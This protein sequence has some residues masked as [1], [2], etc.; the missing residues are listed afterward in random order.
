MDPIVARNFLIALLIGALIGIEREKKKADE[1]GQSFGG[2]RTYTLLSLLGAA[3][4]WL[5]RELGTPWL[6]AAVLL[7]VGA[8]VVASF[9]L[10]ARSSPDMPGLTS[11][12]AAVVVCVL[13]ALVVVGNAMLAVA[14]AVVTSALLA[15]KQPLHSMVKRIGTDDLFAG[16][17]LLIASCI[18]LPLLPDHALDRWGALNPYALWLLVILISA[19][20]LLGYVAVRLLGPSRGAA[21]TGLA[22]GLVSSTATT[23]SFARTSAAQPDADGHALAA[24]VLLA[25]LVMAARLLVVVTLLNAPLAG[26]LAAPLGV[27]ATMTAVFAARHYLA[28]RSSVGPAGALPAGVADLAVRNPF[29]L[30]AAAQFGALF[31]LVMLATRLAQLHAPEVGVYLVSVLAGLVDVDAIALS[32]ARAPVVPG[33]TVGAVAI[34]L[35]VVSNTIVKTAMVALLGRGALRRHIGRAA[36]AIVP[37]AAAMAW[38]LA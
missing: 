37:A 18:V 23:L 15:F 36:A 38:W 20:S 24:G 5:S 33:S 4:A 11:E 13:G 6:L 2:I 34:T 16:I 1:P 21:V 12:V 31:A 27:L 35:A 25:W 9:V 7:V 22:G 10:Q 32:M 17:K 30:A 28:S 29:S 8:A 19:L 3:A 26:V 14:L